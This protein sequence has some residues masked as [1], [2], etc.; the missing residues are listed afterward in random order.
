M[1]MHHLQFTRHTY[2][3]VLARC[4]L[5]GFCTGLSSLKPQ[6]QLQTAPK[7]PQKN[8]KFSK[9]EIYEITESELNTRKLKGS[10]YVLIFGNT[11][12]AM[13]FFNFNYPM[14]SMLFC[15]FAASNIV[16][17]RSIIKLA[18]KVIHRVALCPNLQE[19]EF[20]YGFTREECFTAKIAAIEPIS[21]PNNVLGAAKL[22]YQ[23]FEKKDF[24]QEENSELEESE[25]DQNEAI[26]Y[27][28]VTDVKGKR[29]ENMIV[30]FKPSLFRIENM[31][32]V[33]DVFTLATGEVT[34]Y[35][36]VEDIKDE[37]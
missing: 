9:W 17:L 35:Y 26:Y 7:A 2:F 1:K 28:N 10:H 24:G 31:D 37:N 36:H 14:S 20:Y 3:S 8:Y 21:N 33:E 4:Q 11:A 25:N 30:S 6:T 15:W 12:A 32:L 18:K 13:G 16:R 5:R 22:L 23:D 19:I 34:R 29:W 27:F